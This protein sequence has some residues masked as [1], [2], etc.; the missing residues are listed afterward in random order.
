M[1]KTT[2]KKG[3]NQSPINISSSVA[4]NCSVTC[5]INF[6]YRTSKCNLILSKNNLIIDYDAGSYVMMNHDVYELD[7]ISFTTPA[8]HKIDNN[9]FPLEINLYHRSTAT[10]KML[11]IAVFIEINDTI[12]TSREFFEQ[13]SKSIN[14]A[15]ATQV[16][17]NMPEEWNI[18]SCLP[19][20][21]SF[22]LYN[23]SVP[24]FPCTEDV[25]WII[26]DQTINCTQD[27]YNRLIK[28]SHN[29]ARPIQKV[30]GR[31]IFYNSN[32]NKK[33]NKN[34]GNRMRCYTDKEFRES[35][36]KLTENKDVKV[37]NSKRN[38]IITVTV[39]III[40]FILLLLYLYDKGILSKFI[41]VINNFLKKKIL[42]PRVI[43]Q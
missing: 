22:F 30:N 7:K 34:Y 39:I 41:K 15:S 28:I 23:G 40:L 26:M 25:D 2:C 11:I 36:A 18:Y 16:S 17:I 3:L 13:F 42:T 1:T 32:S 24:R 37:Y 27:F 12:T 14:Q 38:L 33:L 21:K 5:D 6:Y 8:S 10:G 9:S 20:S 31:N 35:C 29:N 43:N 19:V 4:K